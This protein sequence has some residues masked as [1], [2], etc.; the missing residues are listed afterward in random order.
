MSQLVIAMTLLFTQ[1][2]YSSDKDCKM[3]VRSITP[4]E[5]SYR[6]EKCFIKT[7]AN[8]KE[9]MACNQVAQLLC[10]ESSLRWQLRVINLFR[11]EKCYLREVSFSEVDQ[12][13]KRLA[14]ANQSVP[15]A[16]NGN[17]FRVV[18]F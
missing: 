3:Y 17:M 10:L 16:P 11:L 6:F 12:V 7:L 4:T 9:K 15:N 8:C 14:L 2:S 1:S 18:E 5:L 13:N